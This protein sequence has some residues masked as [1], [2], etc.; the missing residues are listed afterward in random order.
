MNLD[1][2]I[3]SLKEVFKIFLYLCLAVLGLHCC[4]QAFSSCDEYGLLSIAGFRL[5]I[6]VASLVAEHGSK[7]HGLSSCGTHA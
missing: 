1:S 6:S 4:L 7:V 2:R 3:P 5:L